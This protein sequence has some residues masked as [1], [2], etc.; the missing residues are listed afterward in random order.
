[1]ATGEKIIETL[2]RNQGKVDGFRSGRMGG[3]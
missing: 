1:M 2:L 3:G